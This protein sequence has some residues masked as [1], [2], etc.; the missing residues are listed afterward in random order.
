MHIL[1]APKQKLCSYSYSTFHVCTHMSFAHAQH[2]HFAIFLRECIAGDTPLL[3]LGYCLHCEIT[4]KEQILLLDYFD[5]IDSFVRV[6]GLDE[7]SI[8]AHGAFFSGQTV[9]GLVK[10]K[11]NTELTNINYIQVKLTGF[12]HVGW[13]EKHWR[14]LHKRHPK[15]YD[16]VHYENHVDLSTIKTII[17]EGSLPEGQNDIHFEFGVPMDLP[18][19][20]EGK[21]GHVR[22]YLEA[23]L[24]RS[25][26][27]T[28][29]KRRRQYI[30]ILSLVDLNKIPGSNQPVTISKEKEFPNDCC[31]IDGGYVSVQ[32][33]LPRACYTPGELM[34]IS[35]DIGN[36]SDRTIKRTSASLIMEVEY[37]EQHRHKI[38]HSIVILRR[39]QSTIKRGQTFT[40]NELS[41]CS[42]SSDN[43]CFSK[44]KWTEVSPTPPLP[45]ST[46]PGYN[47]CHIIQCTYRL[48]FCIF[49]RGR[50]RPFISIIIPLTIG[51]IPLKSSLL[52]ANEDESEKAENETTAS[53]LPY[54]PSIQKHDSND[55]P[56]TASH[57]PSAPSIQLHDSHDL[58]PPS[59][60]EAMNTD[61]SVPNINPRTNDTK[62]TH[63]NWDFRPTYPV[64]T[65][66]SAFPGVSTRLKKVNTVND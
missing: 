19:S 31:C 40:W 56:P 47:Y 33:N 27:F 3:A 15:R 63:A 46:M 16:I 51:S 1:L 14:V 5:T 57:M 58:P 62:D 11:C 25:G 10:V 30:T 22:Y 49:V 18:C 8:S 64:W 17:H 52:P 32:V 7:F 59:Y 66:Q 12:A 53:Q 44:P 60:L 26:I 36:H 13:K 61:A 54:A 20:I 43:G 2:L 38:S 50:D 29:H 39:E 37:Y 42:Q 34:P 23:K 21:H 45:P 41:L 48:E 35:A 9:S 6:M 28:T 24:D 65:G 4:H 55:I